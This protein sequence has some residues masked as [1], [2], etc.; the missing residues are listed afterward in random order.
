MCAYIVHLY[1]VESTVRA[2]RAGT[3]WTR[4]GEHEAELHFRKHQ[5]TLRRGRR[6]VCARDQRGHKLAR[7]A[8]AALQLG[9]RRD[10]VREHEELE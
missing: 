10:A 6:R 9:R 8:H 1:N 3:G 4:T 7:A 2:V 5:L